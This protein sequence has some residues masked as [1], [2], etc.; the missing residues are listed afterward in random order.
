MSGKKKVGLTRLE[1]LGARLKNIRVKAKI[2]QMKLAEILGLN[3]IHGYKYILRLEK[4]LVPNP[5]L[6]TIAGFLS[7]CGATWQDIADVL[8]GLATKT[9]EKKEPVSPS[10]PIIIPPYQ[11][12]PGEEVTLLVTAE[13]QSQLNPIRS[14]WLWH[15]VKRLQHQIWVSLRLYQQSPAFQRAYLTFLRSTCV[16]LALLSK[17][18]PDHLEKAVNLS[19]TLPRELEPLRNQALKQGLDPDLINQIGKICLT[20]IRKTKPVSGDSGARTSG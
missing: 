20:A 15:L 17:S 12:L 10:K 18:D 2:S 14:Q 11:T 6:R 13:E 16:V 9:E 5:T 1:E 19:E 7:A 4:G 3:P 8:P